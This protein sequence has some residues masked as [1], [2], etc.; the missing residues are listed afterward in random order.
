MDSRLIYF[1]CINP[2]HVPRQPAPGQVTLHER[3]WAYCSQ[4]I[5]SD[6]HHWQEIPGGMPYEHVVRVQPPRSNG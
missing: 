4:P 5:T 1:R 3:R 2:D 6:E